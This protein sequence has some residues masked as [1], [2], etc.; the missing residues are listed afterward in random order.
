[1]ILRRHELCEQ[2]MTRLEGGLQSHHLWR[3]R[4]ALLCLGC[5]TAFLSILIWSQAH[6]KLLCKTDARDSAALGQI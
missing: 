1:M 5:S 3:L 4:C 2:A 6:V